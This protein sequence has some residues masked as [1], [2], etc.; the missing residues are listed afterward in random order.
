MPFFGRIFDA[1]AGD[2]I[3]DR[4]GKG[5]RTTARLAVTVKTLSFGDMALD[6]IDLI[7]GLDAADAADASDSPASRTSSR[8]SDGEVRFGGHGAGGC[9]LCG[10]DGFWGNFQSCGQ[11][12]HSAVNHV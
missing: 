2:F 4:W 8:T 6:A 1:V 5:A 7:D 11:C 9:Y 3:E 12:G 10:C